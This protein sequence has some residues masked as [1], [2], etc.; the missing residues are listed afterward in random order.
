MR[1]WL[2]WLT[3]GIACCGHSTNAAGAPQGRPG[4]FEAVRAE[5]SGDNA[6]DT[7]AFVEQFWRLPG[8]SGFDASIHRVESILKNAGFIEESAAGLD[9]RLVYRI[10]R[11]DMPR[12]TWEPVRASLTVVGDEQPLLSTETNRNLPLIN[13]NS[14]PEGGVEAEVIDLG[15][16]RDDA[17]EGL[18]VAGKIVMTQASP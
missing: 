10:R 17:F 5:F 6:F 18:D 12:P 2:G 3:V 14:T 7:T 4:Y 8:N 15:A 13:A 11:R 16:R 9:D 1:Q